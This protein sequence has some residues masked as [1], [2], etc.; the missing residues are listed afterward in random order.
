[1][2]FI[3]GEWRK[4]AIAN[5]EVDSAL[6][7][8]YLPYGTEH[9]IW[10]GKCYVSLVGF[11]FM[12]TRVMNLK[13]PFHVDFEEINLRFYVKRPEDGKW[14]RGVVF[15]KEI[16][17][18]PAI[19]FVANNLFGESY[20]TCPTSHK[21]DGKQNEWRIEYAWEKHGHWNTI[22]VTAEKQQAP[23]EHDSEGGFIVDHLC[24][25]ARVDENTTNEYKVTHPWWNEYK[26]I[27]YNID[28]DFASAF[29][30][31][32][33]FLSRQMP[34]SVMLAEGSELTLGDKKRIVRPD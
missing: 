19:S 10:R 20:E 17:S 7:D 1:M 5:Y 13:I 26:V 18:K 14:K 23:I 33:D 9:D 3:Q 29:G 15:I 27:G 8:A 11:M 25:Y 34:S 28:V 4:L 32:F 30:E 31:K 22:H 21:W 2:S 12:D 16:V 24:G 6:L